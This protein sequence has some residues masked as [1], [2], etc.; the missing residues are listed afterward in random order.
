MHKHRSETT[1]NHQTFS[2]Q[3]LV[4][5]VWIIKTRWNIYQSKSLIYISQR[6]SL[7]EDLF[8]I[9]IWDYIYIDIDIHIYIYVCV[10]VCIH[11]KCIYRDYIHIIY[12]YRE[13]NLLWNPSTW[14][15]LEYVQNKHKISFLSVGGW[16]VCA[17][18]RA[19]CR[20]CTAKDSISIKP[21]V[22]KR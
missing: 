1:W 8:E 4:E 11:N 18:G 9:W 2:A 5:H 19:A 15:S 3:I 21:V 13:R 16:S 22:T 14:I 12:I 10:C 17:W 7:K 20:G 6:F